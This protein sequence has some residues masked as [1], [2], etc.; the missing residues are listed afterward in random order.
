MRLYCIG[1]TLWLLAFIDATL[2]LAWKMADSKALEPSIILISTVWPQNSNP[3]HVASVEVAAL[4][5]VLLGFLCSR[6][7]GAP[8][9]DDL[10]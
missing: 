7:S 8:V 6:G 3:V 10:V 9:R 2:R 5:P 1:A 4:T